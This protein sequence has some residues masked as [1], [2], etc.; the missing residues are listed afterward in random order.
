MYFFCSGIV[1]SHSSAAVLQSW[2][3]LSI[4]NFFRNKVHSNICLPHLL[5]PLNDHFV[6]WCLKCSHHA[7][8]FL[9]WTQHRLLILLSDLVTGQNQDYLYQHEEQN[10]LGIPL[11][12]D[13]NNLSCNVPWLP[14]NAKHKHLHCA[15]SKYHNP[16]TLVLTF[17]TVIFCSYS[18]HVAFTFIFCLCPLPLYIIICFWVVVRFC[19][20]I[21]FSVLLFAISSL[22][23]HVA[24]SSF[25]GG[26]STLTATV[27][28]ER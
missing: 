6:L 14:R 26:T 13:S 17:L 23:M 22:H 7:C 10:D 25:T 19:V 8:R 16:L 27:L 5:L 15:V 2:N 21:F 28:L 18:S 12:M 11:K 20:W 3:G 9:N 24:R 1:C 4:K